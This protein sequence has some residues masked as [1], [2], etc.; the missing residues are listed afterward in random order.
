M[1][2]DKYITEN[3]TELFKKGDQVTMHNCAEASIYKDKV[4]TCLTDS[5]LARGQEEVVF[6]EDFSGY[7]L[8]KFLVKVKKSAH[9]I[10]R[11]SLD[12][13]LTTEEFK[14]NLKKNNIIIPKK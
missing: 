3:K 9:Q 5:F 2:T 12:Q 14:E 13:N 7:F 4:W 11:E 8:A 6:L 1:T 10:W